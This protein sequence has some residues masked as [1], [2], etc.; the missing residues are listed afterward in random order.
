[1]TTNEKTNSNRKTAIIVGVLFITATV[2]SI[3][4]SLVILGPILDAPNY[5]NSVAENET[6]VIVGVLID[7][8][9]SVAVIAIAVMLFPILK[10]DHENAAIGYVGFRILESAILII[11][12][13]SILSVMTLSQEYAQAVAAETPYF[14]T[15]GDLLLAANDWAQMLGAMIVFSITALI[16]NFSLY[17][18]KLVPRFISIWG[19]LGAILML[20]AGLLAMVSLGYLSPITVLLSLPLAINEM[21]LAVWL[22]VKGFDSSAITS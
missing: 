14:Q 1:M 16:L 12:S 3:L 19:L 2:A 7:A 4:G 9:N 20:A 17:Q 18:S 8:I 6:Q 11:G 5:L 10:K 13:I 15:L 22:I 21:V